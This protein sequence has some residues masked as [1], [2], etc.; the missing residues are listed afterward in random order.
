MRSGG[1]AALVALG[2]A[3]G[4]AAGCAGKD[5]CS[6][7]DDNDADGLID[8]VDP[9]CAF[10]GDVEAPDPDLAACSDAVDNDGDGATD[11]DDPG[12]ESAHDDE[13][14]DDPVAGC[15]DGID[16]DGDQLLDYPNDPGCLVSLDDDEEDDCPYGSSCAACSNGVDDD[17]DDI[18]DYPEDLGCDSASDGDEFNADPSVC[19]ASVPVETLPEDGMVDG[20][21]DDARPNELISL[22]CGGSG[23]ESVY[24]IDIAQATTLIATTNFPETAVDTVLYLRSECRESATE[25]TCNDD[26]GE[27]TGSRIRVEDLA[28]GTYYLIVDARQSGQSG[29]FRLLVQK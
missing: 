12:C 23:T 3:V 13:E 6:D 28:P 1:W 22:E 16:N 10:H 11:L 9:G 15:R 19:G 26:V 4:G 17:G 18:V 21:F 29:A 7:G 2:I 27:A 5:D 14:F 20:F 8:S 24:R 25:I